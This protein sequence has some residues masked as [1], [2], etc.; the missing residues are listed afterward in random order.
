MKTQMSTFSIDCNTTD[1]ESAIFI[2]TIAMTIIKSGDGLLK[3]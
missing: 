2:I 3:L 1:I